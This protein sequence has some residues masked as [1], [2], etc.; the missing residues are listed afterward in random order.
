MRITKKT[1]Q[2]FV[3]SK[4][5]LYVCDIEIIKDVC[6]VWNGSYSIN[7]YMGGYNST[8]YFS[9]LLLRLRVETFSHRGRLLSMVEKY[10]MGREK[11]ENER[12]QINR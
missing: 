2:L 4:I 5:F 6:Y 1:L 7:H 11:K 12:K 10:R 3:C 8:L 9:Y